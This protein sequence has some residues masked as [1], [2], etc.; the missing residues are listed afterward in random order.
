MQCFKIDWKGFYPLDTV[1]SELEARKS[2]VYAIYQISWGDIEYCQYIGKAQVFSE[3]LQRHIRDY[4][5][6]GQGNPNY[7]V[8]LGIIHPFESTHITPQQLRDIESYLINI[9]KPKGNSPA[10]KKGY[11]GKPILIINTG[12][13]GSLSKVLCSQPDL[14]K[15]LKES[16]APS[17]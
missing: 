16:L 14:L 2:G 3:R 9:V 17:W 7:H 15:L 11:K 4:V 6:L 8:C 5:H 13:T 10:T 12:K 1:C